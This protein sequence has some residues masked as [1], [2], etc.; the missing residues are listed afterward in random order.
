MHMQTARA[1]SLC[2]LKRSQESIRGCRSDHFLGSLDN[3]LVEPRTSY[4]D[5]VAY[6]QIGVFDQDIASW[7]IL[8]SD[9]QLLVIQDFAL[10]ALMA[11]PTLLNR[12]PG[13]NFDTSSGVS[14][15]V[16]RNEVPARNSTE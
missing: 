4:N 3:H 7:V 13:S 6:A 8:N 2:H 16:T 1:N 15:Y 5:A 9:H 14:T 12:R 11:S 10:L